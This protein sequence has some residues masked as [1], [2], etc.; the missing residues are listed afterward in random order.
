[1]ATRKSFAK[2][3]IIFDAHEQA[4]G[5]KFVFTHGATHIVNLADFPANVRGHAACHGLSQKLGDGYGSAENVETSEQAEGVFLE[6]VDVLRG[7]DWSSKRDAGGMIVEAI[8]RVKTV[9]LEKAAEIWASLP[10]AE[11]DEIRADVRIKAEVAKIRAERAAKR[12]SL[13][14]AES[15]ALDLFDTEDDD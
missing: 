13:V 4:I 14:T 6:L 1:M 15:S 3:T 10:K 5:V 9:T 8:C 7:G 12:A 11:Q 2:K